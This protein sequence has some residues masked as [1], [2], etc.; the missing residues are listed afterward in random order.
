M[1]KLC[2]QFGLGDFKCIAVTDGLFTRD[3][4]RF[5]FKNPPDDK[6][7]RLIE[8]AGL[9]GTRVGTVEISSVHANFFVNHGQARAE[10]VRKLIDLV[11]KTVQTRLGVSLELEIELIGEFS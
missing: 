4:A 9:K 1:D 2:Y 3:D 5:L 8:E 10:D 11:Q 6:A 7:G